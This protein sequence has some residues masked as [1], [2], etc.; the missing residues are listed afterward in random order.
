MGGLWKW[1]EEE[2]GGKTD[3][4]KNERVKI[5]DGRRKYLETG[6]HLSLSPRDNT[7][8]AN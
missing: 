3:S 6:C 5:E 7:P 2:A 4:G 1:E 8:V